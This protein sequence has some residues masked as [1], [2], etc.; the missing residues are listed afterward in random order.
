MFRGYDLRGI[1][2]KD[3][4]PEIVEHIGRAHG[5]YMKRRGITKAVVGRDCRA[6]SEEYSEALMRGYSWAG[7]DTTDIGMNLNII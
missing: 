7:I 6:T 2:D 1:V 3:L 4:T 5:T